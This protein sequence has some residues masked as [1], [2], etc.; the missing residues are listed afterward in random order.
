MVCTFRSYL[1][2]YRAATPGVMHNEDIQ[3]VVASYNNNYS[4]AVGM[5][6]RDARLPK[7]LAQVRN[8][9]QKERLKTYLRN[10]RTYAKVPK[11]DKGDYVL[12]R[13][14]VGDTFHK[15]SDLRPETNV[16]NVLYQIEQVVDDY[17]TK[18]Y[19]ILNM[20]TGSSYAS[21]VPGTRLLA[22]PAY[23]IAEKLPKIKKKLTV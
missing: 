3:N 4:R 20:A 21:K 18:S 7:N 8:Y 13:R 6:P 12:L 11:F 23:Y 16:S 15:E 19:R 17:P 14:R 1:Q 2:R 9:K 10:Y 22:A 5:S